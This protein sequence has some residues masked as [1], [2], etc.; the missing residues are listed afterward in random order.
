MIAGNAYNMLKKISA[1]GKETRQVGTFIA[2]KV[3]VSE[4]SVITK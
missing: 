1:L 2:P 4:L 3:V